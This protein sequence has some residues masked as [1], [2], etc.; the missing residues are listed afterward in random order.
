V[1]EIA[2][3]IGGT[4][5]KVTYFSRKKGGTGGRLHFHR[6]P[7]ESVDDFISFVSSII[8]DKSNSTV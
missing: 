5:S 4:L 2:I 8:T 1:D 6:F 7:T 3:D